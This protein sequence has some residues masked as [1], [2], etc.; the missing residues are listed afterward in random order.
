M[1]GVLDGRF[2]G[3]RA[4][5]G[6]V[7]A[8]S[9]LPGYCHLRVLRRGLNGGFGVRAA[10]TGALSGFHSFGGGGPRRFLQARRRQEAGP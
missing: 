7:R 2:E 6:R 4:L 8:D 5:A 1:A 3:A 10:P 9:R